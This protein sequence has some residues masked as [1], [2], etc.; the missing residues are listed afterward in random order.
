MDSF[1]FHWIIKFNFL[2]Y[3]NSIFS[4]IYLMITN[5]HYSVCSLSNWF[6]NL[7]V[8]KNTSLNSLTMKIWTTLRLTSM[9]VILAMILFHKV[10]FYTHWYNSWFDWLSILIVV[11]FNVPIE[12]NSCRTTRCLGSSFLNVNIASGWQVLFCAI[13]IASMVISVCCSC[14]TCSTVRT[15][16]MQ[17]SNANNLS[18]MGDWLFNYSIWSLCFYNHITSCNFIFSLWIDLFLLLC[19]NCG[20]CCS[21]H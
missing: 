9:M 5:I 19:S 20:A 12:I 13:W 7:I 18:R 15:I 16:I 2:I 17:I 10:T 21:I 11:A 8:F 6:T 1:S 4:H 3:F 14:C